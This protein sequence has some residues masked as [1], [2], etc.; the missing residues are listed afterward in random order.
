M[1]VTTVR[2]DHDLEQA[3][4]T[5][6]ERSKRS[7]SWLINQA[8]REFV[9]H[10]RRD[11]ERWKQTLAAVES[12]ADGNVYAAEDVHAWLRSWGSDEERPAPGNDA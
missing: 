8:V 5:L 2:L 3:L 4:S 7:K 10:E 11:R 12:A 9:E 6:A 1:A